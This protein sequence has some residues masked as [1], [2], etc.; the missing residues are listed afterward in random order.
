MIKHYIKDNYTRNFCLAIGIIGLFSYFA[1][2]TG[3]HLFPHHLERGALF[4]EGAYNDPASW[5]IWGYSLLAG[6]LGPWVIIFQWVIMLWALSFWCFNTKPKY[7]QPAPTYEKIIL[8]PYFKALLLT[9]FVFLSVSY[10]AYGLAL[11]LMFYGTW[12]IYV[13]LKN[14]NTILYYIYSGL[15]FGLAA[16]IRSDILLFVFLLCTSLTIYAIY[17][18]NFRIII[19]TISLCLM[20]LILLIPWATFTYKTI[21]EARL[22]STNGGGVMYIGLGILPDNPWGIITNDIYAEQIAENKLGNVSPWSLKAD[23]FFKQEYVKLI[24]DQPDI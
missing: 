10:F 2:S 18:K 14:Q 5:P 15:I 3:D 20:I 16:N 22:T 1:A 19:K 24:K 13:N 21:G 11:L 4:L 6:V 23:K 8:S 7:P 17:I 12:L 9:P